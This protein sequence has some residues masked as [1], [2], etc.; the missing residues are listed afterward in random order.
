LQNEFNA[1]KKEPAAKKI[2][3]G[4][5]EVFSKTDNEDAL[6]A[7]IAALKSLRNK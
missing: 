2:A 1:F 7:R 3:D 5:T 6:E 4:K